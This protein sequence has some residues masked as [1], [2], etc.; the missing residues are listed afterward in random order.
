[1]IAIEGSCHC[2]QVRYEAQVDP[3]RVTICHCTDCQ[4][5]T[6]TAFRVS[7]SAE[8]EQLRITGEP[9]VYVKVAENG[10][11]RHQHFCGDCGSP[12][13]ASGEGEDSRTW[14]IRWGGIRQ[15]D[16]LIPTRQI[17]RRSAPEWV[18]AFEGAPAETTE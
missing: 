15:R 11:R 2:G 3:G 17:W 10:N 9:K 6:G 7:V 1:M 5:L 16:Q 12:L 4:A 14:N 13:F 18:C 8:R